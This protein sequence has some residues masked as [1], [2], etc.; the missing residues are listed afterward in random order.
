ML[1]HEIDHLDGV[2]ILDRTAA[3]AAQGRAAGA[4]RGRPPTAP[5]P[6]SPSP[7]R[8]PRASEPDDCERTVFLGTS[9]FAATVLAPAGRSA[10]TA[11]CWWSR[12]PTAARAAAASWRRRRSPRRRASSAS[13]CSRPRRRERPETLERIR[14]VEPEVG[15]VCA[16]GQLIRE[17]LLAELELLNVHPSLLPRWRGAA[18]IER[19]IMAGDPETGVSIMRVTEGL[20]SGPVALQEAVP[21]GDGRLRRALGA[22]GRARRRARCCRALDLRAAGELEFDRAGRV[23]RRPTPR[24]STRA[25]RRLDPRAQRASSSSGSVRALHPHIGAYLELAGGE[26]LGVAA[27][28]WP[29]RRARE[30]GRLDGRR[31]GCGSAAARASCGCSRCVPP[32]GRRWT[33]RLICAGIRR[34]AL[35]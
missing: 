17:P 2:L 27:A 15:V 18:P 20:D 1:Q 35:A 23:G 13:S 32:A 6:P 16:F 5:E 10:S 14:A 9:E 7:S 28:R 4:A 24:R 33:P 34:R 31:M 22:A 3:R 26:R 8:E 19:A 11:R 25:E 21:I 12:R 29:A 30:L